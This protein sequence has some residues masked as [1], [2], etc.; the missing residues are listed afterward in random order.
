MKRAISL[1]LVVLLMASTAALASEIPQINGGLFVCAK[2]ALVHLVSGEYERLVTLLPFSDVSP[3]AAEW[4]S[5]VEGNFTTLP[6]AAQT[7]YSVAYWTGNV[8][9]LAIPVS[10]PVNDSIETLV[11]T[12][13]DGTAFSGYGYCTWAEVKGEYLFASYV[14]WNEEYLG[15]DPVIAID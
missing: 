10:E 1:L 8:W 9:K 7:K 2:Q 12:S 15:T 4:Q 3:S 11:L 14:T 6:D 5:F 13:P